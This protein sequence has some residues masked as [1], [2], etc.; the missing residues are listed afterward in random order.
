MSREAEATYNQLVG[1]IWPPDWVLDMPAVHE[2]VRF[3][4]INAA[5]F[6]SAYS[7]VEVEVRQQ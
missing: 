2:S 6:S 7:V 4:E 1:S 3:G 5:I